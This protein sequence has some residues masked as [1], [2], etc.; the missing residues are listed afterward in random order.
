MYYAYHYE[1]HMWKKNLYFTFDR[2]KNLG[3]AADTIQR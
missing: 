2:K 1:G 3:L